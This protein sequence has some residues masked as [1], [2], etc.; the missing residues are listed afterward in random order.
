MTVMLKQGLD[1]I[2]LEESSDESVL[3]TCPLPWLKTKYKRA[4]ICWTK[5]ILKTS[6]KSKGMVQHREVGEPSQSYSRQATSIL[7]D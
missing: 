3:H 5:Y 4:Y 2:S 7:C 6:Q 1:Y